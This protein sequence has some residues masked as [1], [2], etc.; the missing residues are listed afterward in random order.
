MFEYQTNVSLDFKKIWGLIPEIFLSKHTQSRQK[1]RP[2]EVEELRDLIEVNEPP[3]KL[4]SNFRAQ[5]E[6]CW[7]RSKQRISDTVSQL[8]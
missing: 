1:A 8:N 6:D 3:T 2:I 5:F 4:A 7:L